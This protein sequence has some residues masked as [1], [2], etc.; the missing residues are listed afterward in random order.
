V[1]GGGESAGERGNER[2]RE[3]IGSRL[4]WTS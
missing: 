2:G 3:S 4:P 1:G